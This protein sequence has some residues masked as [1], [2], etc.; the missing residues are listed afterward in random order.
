MEPRWGPSARGSWCSW[1]SAKR[2]GP[3]QAAWLAGKIAGL[4]IFPDGHDKLN[5]SVTDTGGEVLVVSQFTLWGDCAKGRRPSFVPGGRGPGGRAPVPGICGRAKE[6]WAW[7]WP[8]AAS[9]P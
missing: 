7:T 2:T 5:L 3:K 4:R 6:G 9:G 8:P 1:A